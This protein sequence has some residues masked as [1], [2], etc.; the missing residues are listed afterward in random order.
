MKSKALVFLLAAIS[1][2]ILSSTVLPSLGASPG[3]EPS[4]G[5]G[6]SDGWEL[7]ENGGFE[8][9]TEGW[10][11]DSPT[12]TQFITV[13]QPVHSGDRAAS[14]K[15]KV[16]AGFIY[17]YQDVPVVGGGYYTLSGWIYNYKD[18]PIEDWAVLRIEWR[19]SSGEIARHVDSQKVYD[20]EPGY[21]ER[22]I[23][24]NGG[25]SVQAPAAATIA[26][27]K[28]MAWVHDSNP[29]TPV[30]FDDLSFTP[31]RWKVYLP[32]VVKNH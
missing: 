11:A 8:E 29:A 2:L 7:L 25:D 14:L 18:R 15:K 1:G 9:G 27:I 5:M 22:R 13:T 31:Q 10:L 28:C 12:T 30:F 19:D 16:G 20:D 3:A 26:R 4:T 21:H 24:Y 6:A 17:I 23:P 32:L